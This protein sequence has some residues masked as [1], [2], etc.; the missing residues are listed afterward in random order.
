M[1]AFNVE[2]F[3]REY[4][5]EILQRLSS[6]D[7]LRPASSEERQASIAMLQKTTFQQKD[8]LLSAFDET[9]EVATK[10]MEHDQTLDHPAD[11]FKPSLSQI[12]MNTFS[13]ITG[14]PYDDLSD[15][16]DGNQMSVSVVS[17]PKQLLADLHDRFEGKKESNNGL[18][19]KARKR[20]EQQ[21]SSQKAGV[22]RKKVSQQSSKPQA[23]KS[24]Q[25]TSS[26]NS[27]IQTLSA[28]NNASAQA[29]FKK[30]R[31]KKYLFLKERRDSSYSTSSDEQLMIM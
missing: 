22:L 4:E 5:K 7:N 25:Y 3:V 28:G 14:K 18:E 17:N 21:R 1:E 31:Q 19:E 9:E 20:K 2:E 11:V 23:F 8:S 26:G 6:H 10:M 12:G 29:I 30:K 16:L 27:S 15:T 24:H 13:T